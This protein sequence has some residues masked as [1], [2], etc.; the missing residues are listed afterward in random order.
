MN[1]L[2]L[3]LVAILSTALVFTAPALGAGKKVTVS[4]ENL[5]FRPTPV[6][7][8]VGDTVVWTNNDEREHSV[9]ADDGAFDSGKLRNGKTF[10]KTFDKAGKYAYSSDPSPRTKGVVVVKEK[11]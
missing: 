7:V 3:V 5:K 6:E 10:S 11:K 4:I 1:R 9:T 8:E 2:F